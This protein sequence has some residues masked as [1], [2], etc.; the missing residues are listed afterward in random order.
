[1]SKPNTKAQKTQ[2]IEVLTRDYFPM[3]PQLQ[4]ELQKNWTPEQHRKIV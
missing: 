4:T 1:M 3:I 2:I